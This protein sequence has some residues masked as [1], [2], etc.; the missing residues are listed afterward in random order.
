MSQSYISHWKSPSNIALVKYWGKK[1][2]QIPANPSISFTLDNA[3]TETSV[4]AK[5]QENQNGILIDFLFEG[6]KNDSFKTKIESFLSIVQNEYKWLNSYHL[7]INSSN[8]FPHSSG[9]ASSASAFS[10]LALCL[11]DLDEKI[12][13]KTNLHF[14]EKA[15]YWARLG[16]GSACRSV[17]G[18]INLWGKTNSYSNSSDEFSIEISKDV[19]PIYT[20]FNDH[21]LIIEKGKKS[22]S[23]TQGHALLKQH[24]FAEIRYQTAK[25]NTEKLISILKTDNLDDFIQLVESEALMLHSLMMTSATPFILMKPN[26]LSVIEK[27]WE[28]RREKNVPILFTLDAGANVHLLS[29]KSQQM[30]VDNFVKTELIQYCQD[31]QYLH[32]SVGKG[33]EKQ[34]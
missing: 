6:I 14:F 16:S 24:P 26:T 34:V 17:Y 21:I 29:P 10:A 9:I 12:N 7:T 31:N 4:E 18:G 11:V 8:T 1:E 27:I 23:S 3:L 32:N 28:Y 13:G 30:Q 2:N 22:V 15:S 20:D 5:F 25:E 33:P 19:H